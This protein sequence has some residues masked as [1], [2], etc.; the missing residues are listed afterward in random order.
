M[1][2][3]C[4]WKSGNKVSEVATW[5]PPARVEEIYAPLRDLWCFRPLPI[6]LGIKGTTRV[7][8]PWYLSL[9]SPFPM[10]GGFRFYEIRN[11]ASGKVILEVHRAAMLSTSSTILA[12]RIRESGVL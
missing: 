9:P 10:G 7:K 11:L 2:G 12:C 8:N 6:R 1:E 3:Y 5:V 4:H